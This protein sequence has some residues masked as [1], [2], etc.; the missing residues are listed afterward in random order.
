MDPDLL[1]ALLSSQVYLGH[2]GVGNEEGI[3]D[4]L[5]RTTMKTRKILA[6][7][8]AALMMLGISM[9]AAAFDCTNDDGDVDPAV[10]QA[11]LTAMA[12]YL[13]CTDHSDV[14]P[15]LWNPENPIWEKRRAPSCDIHQ[16]LARNLYEK[17][18]FSDGSKPPRNKNNQAAGAA[19]NVRNGQYEEAIV[20]LDS[21]VAAILK[22]TLNR[23]YDPNTAAAQYQAMMFINKAQVARACIVQLLP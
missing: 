3:V 22:S 6:A 17:R 14:L 11:N 20:K 16:K 5:R 15:G 13:R 1:R 8:G 12:N 9:P 4:E 2:A 19:W 23:S 21:F 7:F 10:I 18:Q